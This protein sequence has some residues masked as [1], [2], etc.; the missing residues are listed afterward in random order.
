MLQRFYDKDLYGNPTDLYKVVEINV[1]LSIKSTYPVASCIL[2]SFT[3]FSSQFRAI[4]ASYVMLTGHQVVL[5]S[6][7]Q[8]FITVFDQ[9]CWKWKAKCTLHS[10]ENRGNLVPLVLGLFGQQTLGKIY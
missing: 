2:L 1:V 10:C 6:N 5:L 3:N 7:L 4:S 8:L 9:G